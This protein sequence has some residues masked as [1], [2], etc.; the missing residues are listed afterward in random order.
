MKF[1]QEKHEEEE[2]EAGPSTT[3]P[4]DLSLKQKKFLVQ[5]ENE[6]MEGLNQPKVILAFIAI[7]NLKIIENFILER[8]C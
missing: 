3:K 6:L 2:E 4:L 7:I 8:N 5:I 1:S